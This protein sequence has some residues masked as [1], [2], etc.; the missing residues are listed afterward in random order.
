V[1]RREFIGA[2][3]GMAL[4]SCLEAR[5]EQS[6]EVARIGIILPEQTNPV[7]AQIYRAL[8][9]GLREL[10]YIEGSNLNVVELQFEVQQSQ[11]PAELIRSKV[12]LLVAIGPELS[13]K[14]ALGLDRI[15]PIVIVAINYDPIARGYVR[16]LARP[17]GNI[18]GLFY[19]QPELA[20]KQLELL[21]QALPERKRLG[22]LSDDLSA[23]QFRAAEETS[24]TLQLELHGLNLDT[25]PYDFDKAFRELVQSAPQ[26]LL[27]LSSP[28]VTQHRFRIAE[29]AIEHRL[30]TMFTFRTY[31][32]AGGLMYYGVDN[33]KMGRRAAGY[34]AKLL[35][36][37]NPADL[38]IEQ[39]TQFELVINFKTAKALG[40]TFPLSLL[41]RAD[42]VIE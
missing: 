4:V 18:T 8:L 36:G 20:Q 10:G 31:V 41:G 6:G 14:V 9:A 27:V 42:E 30:P 17:G 24:G 38:P 37:A 25:P 33:A 34:V 12:G 21:T 23:D 39:P 2:L 1:K 35:N 22:V 40:L 15:L 3:G 28:Y 26:M 13:L 32:E 29:L 5:S 11:R 16:S 19:R 7:I